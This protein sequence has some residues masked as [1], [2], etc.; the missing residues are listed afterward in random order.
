M[1]NIDKNKLLKDK[2]MPTKQELSLLN[3]IIIKHNK[4]NN[5]CKYKKSFQ[6]SIDVKPKFF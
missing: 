3:I 2:L 5:I 4:S 1:K 6:E